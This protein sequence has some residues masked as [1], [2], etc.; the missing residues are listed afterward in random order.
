MIADKVIAFL[1][2]LSLEELERLPPARLRLFSEL[3]W[4]W[5]QL[6]ERR[7]TKPKEAKAGVLSRLRDGERPE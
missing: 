1:D 4:H 2:G 7:L 5:H 6:S 3:C